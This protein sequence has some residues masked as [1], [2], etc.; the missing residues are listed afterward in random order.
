[1]NLDRVTF[2]PSNWHF[3]VA[4]VKM[5]KWSKDKRNTQY[6]WR[7]IALSFHPHSDWQVPIIPI[8]RSPALTHWRYL[9]FFVF[10]YKFVSSSCKYGWSGDTGIATKQTSKLWVHLGIRWQIH[11]KKTAQRNVWIVSVDL[12]WI[13]N[14]L[15]YRT[16][17]THI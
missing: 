3:L 1:M 14:P 2:A 5:Q 7:A 4:I 16:Q 6:S 11:K 8:R 12:F 13:D 15:K 9:F 17:A 10:F